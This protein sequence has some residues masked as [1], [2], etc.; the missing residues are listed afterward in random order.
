MNV[1]PRGEALGRLDVFVGEW[2]MEAALPGTSRG[3]TTFAW[4][5]DG[6]FLVQR[7]DAPDPMPNAIGIVSADLDTGAY[8]QHYFDSRGVVRMY[9]MTLA[10]GIW[11]LTRETPDFTPLA[12]SQ[13][14][15]G[16]FSADGN[17][18]DGRWEKREIGADWELDFGLVYSRRV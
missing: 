13:R 9:A 6:G 3:R 8:T 17:T 12:F 7:S 4:E 5:L 14:F 10:D 1:T 11:T 16:T 2:T 18:I 15:I